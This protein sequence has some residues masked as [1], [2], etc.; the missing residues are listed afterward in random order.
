MFNKLKNFFS[1]PEKTQEVMIENQITEQPTVST[2]QTL[3]EQFPANVEASEAFNQ[4][5]QLTAESPKNTVAEINQSAETQT[6]PTVE[7]LDEILSKEESQYLFTDPRVVGWTSNA[8]QEILFSALLLYYQTS[9]TILDVGCGRGDLF[10]YMK[11][12]FQTNDITYSGM[13]LSTNLIEIGKRKFPDAIFINEDIL[14]D[15]IEDKF[16]WVVGSG[17]F[18]LNDQPDMVSYAKEVV[19]KMYE[20]S[21]IGVAFNLLCGDPE[22]FSEEDKKSLI[23]HK[24]S[25][26][27]DYLL[28]KYNKVICR[29]DYLSGDVT[30]IIFKINQ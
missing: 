25:L 1:Q 9:H 26:W 17:L 11:E 8:E 29:H 15:Q 12:I 18:N 10:G 19:D 21:S 30:F 2:E 23:I 14:K 28:E 22:G 27:L 4:A 13:D 20:K 6:E 5:T 3:R 16:D 7:T 24:P